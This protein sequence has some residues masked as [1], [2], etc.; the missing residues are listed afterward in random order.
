MTALGAVGLVACA[1]I[2]DFRGNFVEP[3]VVG[4]VDQGPMDAPDGTCWGRDETPATVETRTQII[5]KSPEQRTPD[6]TVVRQATYE[7][8][9]SQRIV[10]ARED[11]W[12][13][14]PCPDQID[15]EFVMALQRALAVRGY[16]Q[17]D[18]SGIVDAATVAS[19]R[20]FQQ[21]LDLNSGQLSLVAARRLGL[22]AYSREDIR[23]F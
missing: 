4:V 14:T 22:V 8:I 9:Q 3:S 2:P 6:G 10:D 21:T 19:I 20:A 18:A 17:E 1:P 5:L 23:Q 16:F 12:F 15:A 7:T 13:E 11:I